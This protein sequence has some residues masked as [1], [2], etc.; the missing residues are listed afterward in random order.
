MGSGGE[1]SKDEIT[2]YAEELFREYMDF[3]NRLS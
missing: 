3:R 2:L 1:G